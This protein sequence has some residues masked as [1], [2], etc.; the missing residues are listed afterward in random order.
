MDLITGQS[1]WSLAIIF[2]SSNTFNNNNLW[3]GMVFVTFSRSRLKQRYHSHFTSHICTPC[4]GPPCK[5]TQ[6]SPTPSSGHPLKSSCSLTRGLEVPLTIL[7][8]Q[9]WYLELWDLV[10]NKLLQNFIQCVRFI[11]KRKFSVYVM[12][13]RITEY[14]GTS[15]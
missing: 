2:N 8:A 5:Q 15:S 13:H 4:D 3:T 1:L 7:L 12:V 6:K 9:K 10:I 14:R 11:R